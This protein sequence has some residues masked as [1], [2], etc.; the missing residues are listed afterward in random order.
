[1]QYLS[2]KIYHFIEAHHQIK[3]QRMTLEFVQD[4]LKNFLMVGCRHLAFVDVNRIEHHDYFLH[5]VKYYSEQE[6][7]DILKE[8]ELAKEQ[9]LK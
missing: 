9:R 8:L 3:V 1:M 6:R 5:F 4:D 7:H 2:Y